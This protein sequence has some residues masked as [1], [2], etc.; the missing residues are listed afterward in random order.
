MTSN[1]SEF[2]STYK[3]IL[4]NNISLDSKLT[5]GK[6]L[7]NDLYITHKGML[8]GI[9]V[10]I[11]LYKECSDENNEIETLDL[12]QNKS[13]GEFPKPYVSIMHPIL[14]T[15]NGTYYDIY[16]NKLI[17]YEYIQGESLTTASNVDK[18]I[19]KEDIQ[20]QL[21]ILHKLD[22]VFA[23]IIKLPNNHYYL[24]DYGRVFSI[25]DVNLPPMNY[26]IEDDCTPSQQDDIDDLNKL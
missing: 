7:G 20:K 23:D 25:T 26:M 17:V 21:D 4:F 8:D 13:N 10:I 24:I 3:Y 1:I 5:F 15:Q 18:V 14:E 11:K 6:C 12:L 22:L 2:I 16:V 19:L 9:D